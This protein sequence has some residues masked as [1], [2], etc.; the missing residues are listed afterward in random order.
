MSSTIKKR[1]TVVIDGDL[2]RADRKVAKK[3]KKV[4]NKCDKDLRKIHSSMMG[5]NCMESSDLTNFARV[6]DALF[7]EKK[8]L[9]S[10]INEKLSPENW[11]K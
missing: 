8:N 10:L 9:L 6:I 5:M 3:V 1:T 7:K 11:G 2:I 4:L